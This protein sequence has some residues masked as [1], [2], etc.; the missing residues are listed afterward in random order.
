MSA[1]L[2][3]FAQPPVFMPAAIAAPL[4]R[5]QR[6]ERS[7]VSFVPFTLE[8]AE[9]AGGWLEDPQNHK[10]LDFGG[11]RQVLS[12]RALHYMSKSKDNF[13]R[14]MVADHT[15]QVGVIGLQHVSSPFRNAMLWGVRPR[16]RPPARTHAWIE[17]KQFLELGF[18]ELDLHSVYAWVAES[19][20]LSLAN[21][22]RVGFKVQGRQRCAH[23]VD[24]VMQDRILLD[25]LA[26]EFEPHLSG[27]DA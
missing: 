11:G 25:L 15:R 18:R 14:S 23:V 4:A 10:W 20:R 2:S 6:Y 22:E 26:S 8:S 16:L 21:L 17:I 27:G 5:T 9:V 1:V 3:S 19:N 24:G 12:G 7:V 13:I